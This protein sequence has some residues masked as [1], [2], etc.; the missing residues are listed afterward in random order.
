MKVSF[1]HLGAM[2]AYVT[3]YL[4]ALGLEVVVPPLSSRRTLDLGTRYCP[5]MVCAP[6]KLIFGNYVEALEAGAE[7]LIMFGGPGTCRLGYALREQERLLRQWGYSFRSYVFDLYRAQIEIVR[8]TRALADPPLPRLIEALRFLVGLVALSDRVERATLRLR[9]RELE[10]G[11]ATRLRADALSEIGALSGR[12]AL[13]DRAE[14]ILAPLLTAPRD[15]E[16]HVLRIGLTGDA[17]SIS[18]PYLNH[19]LEQRLGDL[20]VEADRQFWISRALD[21]RPIRRLLRQDHRS[22]VK[23]AGRP[24]IGRDIG[25]FARFTVG[26]TVLFARAGYDGI[27]HVAPFNCAPEVVVDNILLALRQDLGVPILSL[28]FDEQTSEAGLVTR[29]EAFVDLLWRRK[30]LVSPQG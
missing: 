5:E 3:P 29:L 10:R 7:G 27:I 17:Y 6:C 8:L 18:E 14:S 12:Q 25:G 28:A 21:F 2:H 16:R 15:A 11:T 23:R 24:Y 20:G 19:N 4:R 22:E 26:E 9:P 30:G 13:A 1:F